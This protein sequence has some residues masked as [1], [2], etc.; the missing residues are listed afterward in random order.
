VAEVTSHDRATLPADKEATVSIEA[1]GRLRPALLARYLDLASLRHDFPLVLTQDGH[2]S[3]ATLTGTV[4]DLLGRIAPEGP[5]GERLRQHV[6]RLETAIRRRLDREPAQR[7]L[8]QLW[9]QATEDLLHEARD[10][11][12]LRASL[13]AARNALPTDGHLVPCSHDAPTAV[14]RHIRDGVERPRTTALRHEIDELIRGLT[15]VLAGDEQRSATGR[16]PARL[17][18]SVGTPHE[19]DFDFQAWSEILASRPHHGPL[20]E[21]R[22]LRLDWALHELRSQRFVPMGQGP[23]TRDTFAFEFDGYPRALDA[24]RERMPEAVRLVKATAVARLE[25][26]ND[27][28]ETAHDAYFHAFG[29]SS[30]HPD[31]LLGF[32]SYLIVLDGDELDPATRAQILDVLASPLPFKVVIVTADAVG[33]PPLHDPLGPRC[34]TGVE[35]SNAA[36][37]LGTAR[38]VQTTTATLARMSGDVR[39]ALAAHGPA[40]INIVTGAGQAG[41]DLPPY[42]A[43]AAAYEAR[44]VPVFTYDPNDGTDGSSQITLS[45]NPQPGADWP[46]R[47]LTYEDEHLQRVHEHVAFTVADLV[48]TDP[49]FAEHV[50]V[51]PRQ[52][53]TDAM[54]PVADF[55]RMSESDRRGHVPYVVAADQND[56]LRRVIVDHWVVAVTEQSLMA[57]RR[58]QERSG[59]RASEERRRLTADL[60]TLETGRCEVEAA[61]RPPSQPMPATPPE[62]AAASGALDDGPLEEP[63]EDVAAT[64]D[65]A[66]PG[67]APSPGEAWIETARCTTCDECT[68][69]N[70]RMFAYNEDKQ[71]CIADLHAGTFR[72]LVQAAEACQVAIIHPGEPWNPDEPGLDDLRQRA[73]AF[74]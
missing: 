20:P 24:Y 56:V 43:A 73:A 52:A 19:G 39:A 25:L 54:V 26:D 38:L 12:A 36:L 27:Y 8:T 62:A 35:L 1:N 49:R 31:D 33:P 69:L 67:G 48:A 23:D 66:E 50:A 18:A 45:K 13:T 6:L 22:R 59:V 72:D 11:D 61:A 28:D 41:A 46:I 53:W 21:A 71:A 29:T 7:T 40:L 15:A 5:E 44:A 30:L 16:D 14:L 42:L 65:V 68:N 70:A 74:A 63:P 32:P 37:G 47:I 57:W 34:L 4:N 3:V 10:V 2:R 17:R 51:T 60:A 58:M 64:S 9:E 55:M